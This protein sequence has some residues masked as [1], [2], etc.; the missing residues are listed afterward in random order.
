MVLKFSSE[1]LEL[2]R[3]A[4]E[5]ERRRLLH[6]AGE[7]HHLGQS[8]QAIEICRRRWAVDNLLAHLDEPSLELV[9]VRTDIAADEIPFPRAA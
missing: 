7:C 2:M 3:C 1:E 9:P 8:P 6:A 5:N 4:L